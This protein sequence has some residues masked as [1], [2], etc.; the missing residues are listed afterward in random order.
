MVGRRGAYF[1]VSKVEVAEVQ[2]P[3]STGG[4]AGENEAQPRGGGEE[5]GH[6]RDEGGSGVASTVPS[7]L[8]LPP[9]R[10][11]A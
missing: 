7:S 3:A 2:V 4:R 1:R 11:R 10:A 6:D 9:G 8:D 5:E